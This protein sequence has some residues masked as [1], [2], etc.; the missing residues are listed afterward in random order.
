MAAYPATNLQSLDEEERKRREANIDN[1]NTLMNLRPP[2]AD[3]GIETGKMV[4]DAY[5]KGGV[6]GAIG[7]YLR[8]APGDF[9][10]GAKEMLV[11]PINKVIA[12]WTNAAIDIG[13]TAITGEVIPSERKLTSERQTGSLGEP[14]KLSLY[15]APTTNSNTKISGP[16]AFTNVAAK[17]RTV[18]NVG[19]QYTPQDLQLKD[20]ISKMDAII[21]S[22]VDPTSGKPVTLDQ[23]EK[24][25]QIK[26]QAGFLR[27]G[28]DKRAVDANGFPIATTGN[29]LRNISDSGRTILS[30]EGIAMTFNEGTDQNVIDRS[31]AVG[32]ENDRIAAYNRTPEGV[33][34]ENQMIQQFNSLDTNK[35]APRQL[36][37]V[38]DG[39]KPGMNEAERIA[40]RSDN[41]SRANARLAANT[42][43]ENNVNTSLSDQEK[44]RIEG[45]NVGGQNKLRD[46]QGQVALDPQVKQLDDLYDR[47]DVY[48]DFGQVIGQELYNKRTGELK[49][50]SS[51]SNPNDVINS[52]PAYKKAFDSASPEKRNE[53]LKKLNERLSAQK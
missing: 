1:S 51:I 24:V 12:P 37:T 33:A 43:A 11:G 15:E 32:N 6:T 16:E 13:K 26:Q 34:K 40:I 41:T 23:I 27:G 42:S 20:N 21:K 29:T 7:T 48:N 50:Q 25:N 38:N 2:G 28:T 53:M 8:R 10:V 22:G 45:I 4:S 47:K 44:N 46:I 35:P 39:I 17:D 18:S 9:A 19:V 5:D 14:K 52:N 36:S 3:R 31:M 30:K 49:K